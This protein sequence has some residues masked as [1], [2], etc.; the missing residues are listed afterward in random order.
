MGTILLGVL[1]FAAFKTRQLSK[2]AQDKIENQFNST[3]PEY[4][5]KCGNLSTNYF[6]FAALSG[7]KITDL[8][9]PDQPTVLDVQ[10]IKLN[11][12]LG[13]LVRRFLKKEDLT[14]SIESLEII[15]PSLKLIRKDHL[16]RVPHSKGGNKFSPSFNIL[17]QNGSL[18]IGDPG[19]LWNEFKVEDIQGFFNPNSLSPKIEVSALIHKKGNLRLLS[20]L[21]AGVLTSSLTLQTQN[22]K[23]EGGGTFNFRSPMVQ[24]DWKILGSVDLQELVPATSLLSI[25]KGKVQLTVQALGDFKKPNITG[26]L[27]SIDTSLENKPL[28]LAAQFNY[29]SSQF[30]IDSQA[31]IGKSWVRAFGMFSKEKNSWKVSLKELT[32]SSLIKNN[33]LKVEGVLTTTLTGSRNGD[34]SFFSGP[35]EISNASLKD[36]KLGNL[37]GNIK[38]NPQFLNLNLVDDTLKNKIELVLRHEDTL[39]HIEKGNLLIADK[40]NFSLKAVLDRKS[41]KMEGTLTMEGSLHG[42]LTFLH[43]MGK[44]PTGEG[45]L[46]LKEGAWGKIQYENCDLNYAYDPTKIELRKFF[47]KQK[48]GSLALEAKTF[49]KSEKNPIEVKARLKNF[50]I[51]NSKLNGSFNLLGDLWLSPKMSLNAKLTSDDF[52]INQFSPGKL[53]GQIEYINPMISVKSMMW[54]NIKLQANLTWDQNLPKLSGHWSTS[55]KTVRE[56]CSIFKLKEPPLLGDIALSGDV[57]GELMNLTV[58]LAG[59]LE[60]LKV[61]GKNGETKENFKGTL[62]ALLVKGS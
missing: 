24:M 17:I 13:Q 51:Q 57:S 38:S 18:E 40:E 58:S 49:K 7:I 35:L 52:S 56:W 5:L 43:K 46:S 39:T 14:P 42:S 2:T 34:I 10:K 4:H 41:Q 47:I 61:R 37:Q 21:E 62:Q 45:A 36:H 53:S 33:L 19:T 22:S 55:K 3:Y 29:E 44:D 31:N 8:T 15:Q 23:L 28:N 48:E 6:S 26:S 25:P 59:Q 30:N 32:L 27:K 1:L 20:S 12:S 54:G 11:F 9:H 60:N 50:Q 16:W